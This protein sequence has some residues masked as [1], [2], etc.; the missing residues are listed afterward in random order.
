MSRFARKRSDP[1]VKPVKRIE[2]SDKKRKPKLILIVLLL[3]LGVTLIVT[4]VANFLVVPAGWET[5]QANAA[6][7]ET[8]AG[9][10]VF[11]YLLGDG[12]Q[13]AN[14]EQRAIAAIY[15]QAAQ[16]A[17]RIFHEERLF[18]E[19]HNVAY[20]NQHPNEEVEIPKV[21]YDAFSM[22]DK[23]ENRALYL[24]PI[25][26]EYIAMFVS[27]Q[28]WIAKDYDPDKD[29]EQADYFAE[30]LAFT[31]D[32]NGVNLELLG[33]NRVK[34]VVSDAY[35]HYAQNKEITAFID[36]YW[37]KNAFI[38]DYLAEQMTNAGYTKG[39]ISSF[40]GYTRNMDNSARSYQLNIFDRVGTG[41][42]PAGVLN[43][44]GNLSIVSLRNYATSELAEQLYHQW[45][46]GSIT[47]CHIDPADGRSKSA[48]NDLIGYGQGIGCGEMLMKLYPLYV[49][50]TFDEE[51]LQALTGVAAAYCKDRTVYTTDVSAVVTGL[52][53]RDGV[54]Y[55]W[56]QAK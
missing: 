1:P 19:V 55:T 13:A 41:I 4:A 9:D 14:V 6:P 37:M 44:K 34:L 26:Q 36:F 5:I 38:V 48:L 25:Y 32:K 39:T 7:E 12:N 30:I 42:Y 35:L 22:L 17:F 45:E 33:N 21:L 2:V 20:L 31:T 43:Y 50:Q 52:Y 18:D 49:T 23:Y 56:Q 51:A 46:D 40:D 8:C 54:E 15:T 24:A 53:K 27:G 47:S 29:S 16:D 10:F 11:R 28:D 3:A